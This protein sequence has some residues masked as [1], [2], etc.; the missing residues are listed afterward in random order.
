MRRATISLLLLTTLAGCSFGFK[1]GGL[2]P[3]L[4]TA[5][6]LPFDNETTDPTIGQQVMLAVKEA[7]ERRLGLRASGES[8]ADVVVRGKISRYE[9][10][11]PVAFQGTP[12][13]AGG[14]NTVSVTRRLVSLTVNVELVERAT[15]KVLY[16]APISVDGDYE[17]GREAEGRRRALDKLVTKIVDGAQLQW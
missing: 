9:P 12:G 5:V 15:S 16:T 17:P 2:P 8:Q 11:L 4:R 6:V 10:D 14:A 3:G 7:I 13:T 1:G